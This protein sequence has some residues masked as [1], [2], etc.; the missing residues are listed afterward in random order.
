[1]TDREDAVAVQGDWELLRR[2]VNMLGSLLGEV[3]REQGGE[4]L[5]ATVEGAR[6]AARRRRKGDPPAAAELAEILEG[7]DA[8]RAAEVVRAFSA[9]FALVNMG[10][11]VHRIRRRRAYLKTGKPQP[12]S[13]EAV[14]AGL[15]ERGTALDRVR[16][17]LSRLRVEPVFTAHPTEAVRRT[18][19]AKEQR[20]AR[21]LIDRMEKTGRTPQEDEIL[22]ARLREEVTT[23]WQTAEHPGTGR[24]V[25][26]EVEHVL[27]YLTDVLYRVAPV[28]EESVDRAMAS[29]YCT[30]RSREI[31]RPILSFASWVGGDMD[32]NP[33]VGPETILATLARHR[34]L[35][36]TRYADEVRELF[37]HLSQS[38]SRVGVDPEVLDRCRRYAEAAPEVDRRIPVR[39]RD[40]PYR[41]L[42]WHM[43]ERLDSARNGAG[44]VPPYRSAEELADDLAIIAASLEHNAGHNAGL[45]RVRRLERR[46]AIF[47]FH[48][49]TL[50]IRQ[51]ASVHRRTA[52]AIL[53]DPAFPELPRAARTERLREALEAGE[54]G[55]RGALDD[56]AERTLGVFQ[57]VVRAREELGEGAIGPYIISMAQG[58]DDALAVLLLA[59]RAGLTDAAGQVPLDVAPLFETV[60]D[61]ARAGETLAGLLNEPLYRSHVRSRGD[62]QIVMLGYSDSSKESGIAA[63]RWALY[64]AEGELTHAAGKAG[65]DLTLFHGRGGTVSRGGSKPRAGIL[66]EPPGAVRGRLRVT[67][68]GEIIHAKYGLRGIALRT[69]ELTTG[70]VLEATL[71]DPDEAVVPAEWVTVMDTVAGASRAAY[72]GLVY[73]NELFF[74]YFREATPIDVIERLR[75]G[76]RPP[77]RRRTGRIEDLRAIPWV[78]SW[79]QNRHLLPGWL[80]LG[81]GLA[82]GLAEHG[83]EVFRAMA[84]RW[85]FFANLLADVEMVLAKADLEIGAR[86][87]GLAGEAGGVIFPKITAEYDRT[88][89]LILRLRGTTELLEREPVLRRSIRLRNPYVDTI[90]LL[91]VDLLRRWRAGGRED[92]ALE[93][94]LK[95]TVRGIARGMQNTG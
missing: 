77:V 86:Y 28:L 54:M 65:V 10:E 24:T 93:R 63:S 59:R 34:E 50:D 79:V 78:F 40:M 57:A 90:S 35:I 47:G 13:L 22:A 23:L 25:G 85:P 95:S 58:A 44:E 30:V 38:T 55:E 14:L 61:L 82:A 60:P 81:T 72:R 56:E 75:I 66:A 39:H 80:G 1:M 26:D 8:G 62:R 12:G 68:Q 76:S 48:L 49:A 20:I 92:A 29:V 91:Q 41:M 64:R 16:E 6:L 83:E 2:D 46:L 88:R 37:Q 27:F 43:W 94:V 71:R 11:R 84:A 42:L 21:L 15:A 53:G 32:G 5:F 18:I 17:V 31:S 4:L 7:L 52:A 9:Y 74:R 70:A 19:L 89:E 87:A 73:E 3:L 36:L 67:E 69:L 33:N 45:F 51:D